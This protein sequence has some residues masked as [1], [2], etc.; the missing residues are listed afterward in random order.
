MFYAGL[1]DTRACSACTCTPPKGGACTIAS[2]AIETGCLAS[3]GTLSA[4]SACMSFTGPEPVK[5]VAA[6]TLVDAGACALTGGG[7]P[8]GAATG[9]G[10]M[11]FCCAL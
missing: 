9:T 3:T 10:A 2:P 4:P 1:D 6:P 11:S 7:T 5:L 8:S